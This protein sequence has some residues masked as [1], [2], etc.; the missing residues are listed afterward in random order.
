[1]TSRERC[2]TEIEAVMPCAPLLAL[3]ALR[4]PTPGEAVARCRWRPCCGVFIL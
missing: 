3:I 1:V 4:Y 2:L